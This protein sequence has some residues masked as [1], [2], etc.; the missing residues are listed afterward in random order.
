MGSGRRVARYDTRHRRLP[1]PQPSPDLTRQSPLQLTSPPEQMAIRA[2]LRRIQ[3]NFSPP[4]P[5][6]VP[7]PSLAGWVPATVHR[8]HGLEVFDEY[9]G[10]VKLRDD[11]RLAAHLDAEE[12]HAKFALAG[13]EQFQLAVESEVPHFSL[14]GA[15]GPSP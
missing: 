13:S 8:A 12:A 15:L 6:R 3:A 7:V 11:P 2:A 9:G 10:L 1:A 14:C 5:V 4:V